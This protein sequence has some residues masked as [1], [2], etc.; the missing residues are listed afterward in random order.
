MMQRLGLFVAFIQIV[1]FLAGVLTH[2]VASLLDEA[3]CL[4]GLDGAALQILL[5]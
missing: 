4:G 3:I 5:Y 1:G 2:R